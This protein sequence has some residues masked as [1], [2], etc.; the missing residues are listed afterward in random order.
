MSKKTTYTAAEKKA[1]DLANHQQALKIMQFNEGAAK[2]ELEAYCTIAGLVWNEGNW[3]YV[4]P[5]II[6][7]ELTHVQ[8]VEAVKAHITLVAHLFNPKAYSWKGRLMIAG[9]FLFN[10]KRK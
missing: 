10:F 4:L 9:H 2:A 6:K 3:Q 7:H 8:A 5:I 1:F